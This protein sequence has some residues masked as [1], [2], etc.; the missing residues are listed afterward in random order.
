MSS[1]TVD[2]GNGAGGRTEMRR[3][4]IAG[5]IGTFVEWYDYGS[6][7]YLA[8]LIALVF[9]PEISTSAGLMATFAVFAIS[10]FIRPLGGIIWGHFGDKIGRKQMLSLSI[11][12][13]SGSTFLIAFLPSYAMV[14]MLAPVLLLVLRVVQGFSAAGEYAGAGAFVAEY[15]PK[16]RRGL[17]VSI[18]PASTALGLLAG[19]LLVTL[20]TATLSHDQMLSWGWRV[21]FLIAGPLGLVGRYIR[22]HLEDTPA[23]RELEQEHQVEQA[24]FVKSIT[25][26]RRETLIALGVTCL[27]AVG[28]YIVLSYMPTYLLTEVHMPETE[29]FLVSTVTAAAYVLLIFG[30]GWLSDRFGRKPMLII[31]SVLFIVLS[32]PLFMLLHSL[33]LIGIIGVQ[34]VFGAMLA[35]NDGNLACFVSEIFPTDVRYSG[36]GFTFNVANAL[37]GGTA[38]FVATWLISATGNSL[39]PAGYVMAAAVVALVAVLFAKETA[40]RDLSLA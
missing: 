1:G 40:A 36:F 23:F 10:F 22:T 38:P 12:I 27:N 25:R 4:M 14:G 31:A 15:A 11:L 29:A 39:A 32:V 17:F 18:V 6:Y 37:F 9:F 34:I 5:S 3:Y 24:P 19:S 21:P 33:T 8:T 13:M 2:T 26:N 35:A 20:M 28:F 30:M 16:H 7:G